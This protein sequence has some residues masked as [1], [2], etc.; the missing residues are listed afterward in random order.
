MRGHPRWFK[1]RTRRVYKEIQQARSYT[2]SSPQWLNHVS[3]GL[4]QQLQLERAAAWVSCQQAPYG[5]GLGQQ[6]SHL[7]E[8]AQLA[9]HHLQVQWA[10]Q[11]VARLQAQQNE[12]LELPPAQQD[13][14]V[15]FDFLQV[16]KLPMHFDQPACNLF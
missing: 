2:D 16:A 12:K 8:A 6:T 11:V 13:K 4:V 9:A 15:N 7:V 10:E 14:Q 1:I 5:A 3:G